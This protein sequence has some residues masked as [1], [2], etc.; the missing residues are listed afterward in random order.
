M[1]QTAIQNMEQ[2][3]VEKPRKTV[4]DL[5]KQMLPEIR[6]ALPATITPERFTRIVL[7]AIST[8]P[9]LAACTP[10]SL[11]GAMMQAAQLGMEA[12]TPLGQCYLIPYKNKG[13]DEVQFQ[14]G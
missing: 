13:V 8:T 10:K 11:L 9:Q 5:I 6:K 2:R 14:L 3:A 4:Q 1:T 7:S 12:N